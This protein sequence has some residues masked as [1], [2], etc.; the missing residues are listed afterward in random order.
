MCIYLIKLCFQPGKCC[1]CRFQLVHAHVGL[2]CCDGRSL[3]FWGNKKVKGTLSH[4]LKLSS[5]LLFLEWKRSN[6]C[7]SKAFSPP[8]S[9]ILVSFQC[10]YLP[11]CAFL[12]Q[13]V[14]LL[15]TKKLI[16]S[17]MFPFLEFHSTLSP[18]YALC[19]WNVQRVLW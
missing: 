6:F 3:S 10:N 7:L 17:P 2:L 19:L 15:T 4:H 1:S 8:Q 14:K 16:F 12:Q 5:V 13:M 18:Y 11:M 9:C